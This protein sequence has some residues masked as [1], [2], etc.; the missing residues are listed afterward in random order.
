[1][2][3]FT[4]KPK[5]IT[6]SAEPGTEEFRDEVRSNI[7]Y[8]RLR[9]QAREIADSLEDFLAKC[10]N[11]PNLSDYLDEYDLEHIANAQDAL[12]YFASPDGV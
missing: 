7:K 4:V 12:N 10:S 1:M 11:V 8:N 2:K 5:T 9:K 3:K 6:A